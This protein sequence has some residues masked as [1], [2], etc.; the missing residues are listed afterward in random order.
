MEKLAENLNS[1]K[2]INALG[3][4][5]T[6]FLALVL[7]CSELL[8][9]QVLVF[10]QLHDYVS[11]LFRSNVIIDEEPAAKGDEPENGYVSR[12]TQTFSHGDDSQ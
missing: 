8:A 6:K 9:T 12:P 4:D 2:W 5:D 11:D 3:E 1:K 7:E 10:A